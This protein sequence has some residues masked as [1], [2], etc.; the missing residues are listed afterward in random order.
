AEAQIAP[1]LIALPGPSGHFGADSGQFTIRVL[2]TATARPLVRMSSPIASASG[3]EPPGEWMR[4][5]SRRPFSFS[6]ASLKALA[7]PGRMRPSADSHSGQSETQAGSALVT[8]TKRIG[9]G[10]ARRRAWVLRSAEA[11]RLAAARPA[12][13]R[14]N[15]RGALTLRGNPLAFC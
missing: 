13:A 5:G 15:A 4:I 10:G 6:I 7:E 14:A 9:G 2:A 11:G 8:R 3:T 12:S 1:P